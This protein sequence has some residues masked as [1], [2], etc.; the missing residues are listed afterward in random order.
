[1]RTVSYS[2]GETLRRLSCKQASR[3]DKI[4]K[5]ERKIDLN[6]FETMKERVVINKSLHEI[7]LLVVVLITR[8]YVSVIF[9]SAW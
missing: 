7:V 2:R 1:M 4:C 8:P 5:K 9:S 6:Q 3:V